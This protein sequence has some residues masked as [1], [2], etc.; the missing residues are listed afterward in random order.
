MKA[1]HILIVSLVLAGCGEDGSSS[2]AATD[3]PSDPPREE[4][5]DP[6]TTYPNTCNLDGRNPHAPFDCCPAGTVCCALCHDENRC[7]MNYDCRDTCPETLPCTGTGG[8][9]GFSCYYDPADFTGTVY[10]PLPPGAPPDDAVACTDTCTTGVECPFDSSWGD[11][12]LCCPGATTC[13]T[14]GFGLPFCQ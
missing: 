13:E 1:T 3:I 12:A 4:A 8:T 11:A 6:C 10:C 14:S 9:G 2:D 5:F 7:E